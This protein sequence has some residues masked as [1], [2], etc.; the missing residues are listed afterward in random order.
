MGG[1]EYR[2]EWRTEFGHVSHGVCNL[3]RKLSCDMVKQASNRDRIVNNRGG[4]HRLVTIT[5]RCHSPHCAPR[6]TSTIDNVRPIDTR[7]SLQGPWRQPG[8][9]RSRWD[10]SHET[11]YE[12][13]R[14]EISSFPQACFERNDI[15]CLPRT[16][17][18]NR[19]HLHET[20]RGFSVH[21]VT[22]T[23]DG[24]VKVKENFKSRNRSAT[25][26]TVR[27]GVWDFTI[28]GT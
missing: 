22:R 21:A 1:M 4:I 20:A 11:S 5:P 8:L 24:L 26:T 7:H 14:P 17:E 6:R 18:T 12:T 23:N 3:L 28:S 13:Y 15:D 16:I 10:S 2:V 27:G 25:V 19:R 9:H